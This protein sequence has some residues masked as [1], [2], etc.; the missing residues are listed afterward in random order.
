MAV[1]ESDHLRKRVETVEQRAAALEA[2]TTRIEDAQ[3]N[4]TRAVAAMRKFN[5]VRFN[6]IEDKLEEIPSKLQDANARQTLEFRAVIAESE[7][8]TA[9]RLA[10]AARMWPV[11]A[12]VLVTGAV[13]L[14]VGVGIDFV[15]RALGVI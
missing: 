8:R 3:A 13:T 9:D 6:A 7:A 5:R 12:T 15:L 11:W 4:L 10:A 14:L 2:R 1:S